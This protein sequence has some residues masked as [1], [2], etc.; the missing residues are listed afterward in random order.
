MGR[1]RMVTR[2]V[3]T[4]EAHALCL[5]VDT[6]E[7]CTKV[8]DVPVNVKGEDKML[9]YIRKNEDTKEVKVVQITHVEV[10]ETLYGM[11]ESEFI[12]LAKEMPPRTKNET[13]EKE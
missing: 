7:P 2:T 11:P 8:F 6:A 1:I 5:N 3:T 10:K 12:K 13:E 4:N 9:N